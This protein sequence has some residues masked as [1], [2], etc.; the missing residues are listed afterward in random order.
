MKISAEMREFVG[1]VVA[2]HGGLAAELVRTAEEIVGKIEGIVAVCVHQGEKGEEI[3][4]KLKEAIESVC[5]EEGVIVL[6]DIFGGSPT[7]IAYALMKE[8]KMRII[9]GVNLPMILE[10][11][12]HR[13]MRSLE[14]LA[15]L[16]ERTGKV[17][18]LDAQST[19]E[20]VKDTGES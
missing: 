11:A 7:N 1:I 12:L 8:Y 6:T 5:G 2:T 4:R 13:H 20:R 16:V 19:I 17:S 3:R 14:D 10:L 9:C 18:V 15:R